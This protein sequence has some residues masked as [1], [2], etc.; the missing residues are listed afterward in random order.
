V[1]E[2]AGLPREV[3]E[4][5]LAQV[6]LDSA[7]PR[8]SGNVAALEKQRPSLDAPPPEARGHPLWSEYVAYWENRLAEL[9]RREAVRPPLAWA[10]Y[11][12]MRGLFA[13]GLVFERT[14]VELLR[15]DA[16]LPKP[17]RRFLQDF[18]LPRI[19]TYV[20]VRKPKTGL[21][22]VDVLVIEEGERAAP[23]PRV[24]VFSFKS[25]N[26]ARLAAR[27]LTTQMVADAREALE[28]Y[29]G[30]LNI[31]RPALQHLGPEVTVQRI[32]LLYEGGNLKP[33]NPRISRAAVERTQAEVEG[34]EVLFQ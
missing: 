12:Q 5:R 22:F 34:V 29:G 19:E 2:A 21:R 32:R 23:R 10:G 18:D 33:D 4:A 27:P 15:A 24:E 11:E 16:A 31:R 30:T 1:D 26:L 20:G 6:E 13:R 8:L 28:Y 14:M 9:H 7:G 25:R 3:V 17:R